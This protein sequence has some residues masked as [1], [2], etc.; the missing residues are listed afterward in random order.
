MARLHLQLDEQYQAVCD[1]CQVDLVP[2]GGLI[3]AV[4]LHQSQ[5]LLDPFEE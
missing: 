3:G 2:D 1:Q 5:M 4:E